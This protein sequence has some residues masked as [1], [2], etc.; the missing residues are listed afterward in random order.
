[1]VPAPSGFALSQAADVHNGPVSAATFKDYDAT[2]PSQGMYGHGVIAITM[3]C[4][5]DERM[6]AMSPAKPCLQCASRRPC[7]PSAGR[8][9][10]G[11][12]R[13]RVTCCRPVA[14]RPRLVARWEHLYR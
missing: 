13:R 12:R 2:S 8:P 14:R 6:L 11:C 1:M 10:F 7:T 9:S 5:T 3:V 4:S